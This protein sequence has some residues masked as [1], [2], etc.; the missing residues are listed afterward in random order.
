MKQILSLLIS[1]LVLTGFISCDDLTNNGA[2]QG[3]IAFSK[4]TL[5]FDTVFTTVGSATARVMVYNRRSQPLVIENVYLAGGSNSVFRVNVDGSTSK[6]HSFGPITLRSRDSMY[7]FVEVKINPLQSD[8]AV[9]IRDSLLFTT[10]EGTKKMV[11]EAFGQDMEVLRSLHI[12]NDTL[13]NARLPYL[14]YGDLVVD[15]AA[16]LQLAPG[17][18]LFFHNN[19]NLLVYGH[20]KA[21]GTRSEP[22]LIRG[23]RLDKIGFV[24]PVPYNLVA[25]QWGGIYLRNPM[26]NHVLR[27]VNVNSGYVGIYYVNNNKRNKPHLEIT[28][29]RIHNF[30]FYNLVA[31]NGDMT[32]SNSAI[33]NSG[34]YTVY[35]NGGKHTFYHCTIANY[36]N[37]PTQSVA[38]DNAPAFMMMTLARSYPMETKVYNS[39]I[40]GSAQNE[41]SLASRFDS[42]Y[43]ADIAYSYIKRTKALTLSQFRNI[44]WSAPKDTVFKGTMQNLE[45]ELTYNFIPDSV[46]PLRGMADPEMAKRFPFDLNGRNRLE[47]GAPDA[48]AYEWGN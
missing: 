6:D 20:L 1:F 21:E 28:D 11:L 34:G 48:G 10:A 36:F 39:V 31:V 22:I 24:P 8:A 15:S 33:T 3:A 23:D 25:G 29:C 4:D 41:L 12:K 32:V 9:L 18:R 2:S 5:T 26:G 35:L 47:D 7:I 37:N 42:L 43:K 40:A 46:S 27:H 19:S 45:K 44:R 17:T 14:I 16:T 38:R 30:L 13:L